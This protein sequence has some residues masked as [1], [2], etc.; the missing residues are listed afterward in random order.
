MLQKGVIGD[1]SN[2]LDQDEGQEDLLKEIMLKL[3]LMYEDTV[4]SQ[5]AGKSTLQ[6]KGIAYSKIF[7]YK[8][9]HLKKLNVYIHTYIHTYNF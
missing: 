5:K 8:E 2:E 6:L 7:T 4:A 1:C 3:K 9:A